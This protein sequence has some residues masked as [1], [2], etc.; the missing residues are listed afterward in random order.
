MECHEIWLY[1]DESQ[2][3][4]LGGLLALCK[5]CHRSKHMAL[6]RHKGWEDVAER[7]MMRVNDWDR[8]TL[9]VYLEESFQVFEE[10][11][12]KTWRLDISWLRSFNVA[13][14]DVLDRDA[15]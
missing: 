12:E 2:V 10:R 7:H 8:E 5:A 6:A 11:S 1:D 15:E 9:E 3:Q 13:I 14:P 4:S